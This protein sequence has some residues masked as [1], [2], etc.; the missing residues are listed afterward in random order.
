[1][2][3]NIRVLQV[4]KHFSPDSGGIETVTKNISEMLLKHDIIADV[5]CTEVNGPYLEC[6][7]GYKVLRCKSDFSFGNKRFSWNY[8]NEGR[9][10]ESEYDCA[11]VHMPNPL[12]VLACLNWRKPL[13]L[14]WHADIPQAAI[15]W[16]TAFLDSLI[17]RK[18]DVIIGPTPIHLTSS[19]L[20]DIGDRGVIIPF[21][22]NRSDIPA[23][24]NTT[25]FGHRLREFRRGRSMSISV[26]RLVAYKGFDVLIDAARHF[27][28]GLCAVVV[29]S[30][31]LESEL[32]KRVKLAQVE[33]KVFLA[34][35][36][37]AEELADTFAQSRMGC[38]PSTT[39]AEMYGM[40]QVETMAFGLPMVST[41]LPKSGVP[42]VNKHQQTGLI[43]PPY[44]ANAL[45]HAMMRL[46]KD[47]VLWKQLSSGA[48]LS[49]AM[50]HDI[51]R[52]SLQYASLIHEIVSKHRIGE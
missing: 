6:D 34:G 30:G 11:I 25:N 2:N 8:I 1:M 38:M 44:D 29:G 51:A 3:S 9:R 4:A 18:A 46:A 33:D 12:A 22:F 52:V 40:T 13:L 50:D 48:S 10:L 24:T 7:R 28:D 14:L 17:I 5:L 32:A 35:K 16:T 23:A 15:R 41:D 36:L 49:I 37:T 27:D 47:E 20:N 19:R 26:G 45:A 42:F 31:P 21:P 43:V 39:A